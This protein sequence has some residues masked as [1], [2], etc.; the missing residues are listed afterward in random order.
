MPYTIA[1]FILFQFGWFAGVLGAA[2]NLSILGSVLMAM[3]LIGHLAVSRQ[4]INEVLLILFAILLGTLW[5]SWLLNQGGLSFNSC[6]W[7][8]AFAPYWI[9]LLWALFATTI[10]HSLGWLKQRYTLAAI[11]GAIAGPAAYYGGAR[12]GAVE[13]LDPEAALLALSVGWAIWTPLLCYVA[14]LLNR[15][16][17]PRQ[18]QEF[19]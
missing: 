17:S 6:M 15:I 9:I 16:F 11:L 2:W 19:I 10:N 1:N 18:Q 3:I 13:L 7:H 14:S 4:T 12:L 8:A 5:D